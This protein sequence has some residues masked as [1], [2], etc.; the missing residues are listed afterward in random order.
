MKLSQIVS[1]LEEKGLHKTA[2]NVKKVF[3]ADTRL[4]KLFPKFLESELTYKPKPKD[5]KF[6]F[7][8]KKGVDGIV[9][10]DYS[11][12]HLFPIWLSP[13]RLHTWRIPSPFELIGLS[14]KETWKKFLIWLRNK[15]YK[16]IK[17][18]DI[19]K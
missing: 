15:G 12:L 8:R 16:Q 10:V 14:Q 17:P 11:S 2:E 6:Y 7:K 4:L 1:K 3:G 18:S 19:E 5:I 13:A 9:I